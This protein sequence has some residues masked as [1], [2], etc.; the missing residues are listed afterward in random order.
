LKKRGKN[1]AI[2]VVAKAELA[3]SYTAQLYL[4]VRLLFIGANLRETGQIAK[5]NSADREKD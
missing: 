2:I 3:Q 4:A 5:Q 1:P